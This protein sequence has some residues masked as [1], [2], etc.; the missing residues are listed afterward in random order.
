MGLKCNADFKD[1][2]EV[3]YDGEIDFLVKL[4]SEQLI[5]ADYMP[6]SMILLYFVRKVLESTG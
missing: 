3:V 5:F 1:L 4:E 2:L 6:T